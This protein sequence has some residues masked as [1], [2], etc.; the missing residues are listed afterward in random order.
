M[1]IDWI[2]FTQPSELMLYLRKLVKTVTRFVTKKL[3]QF[4]SAWLK[5]AA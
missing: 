4:E 3:V 1:K 2:P 5:T